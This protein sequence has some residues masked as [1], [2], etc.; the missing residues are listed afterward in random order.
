MFAVMRF[1]KLKTFGN[2]GGVESHCLRS[3]ETL[4]ADP[5]KSMLNRWIVGDGSITSEVKRRI[6]NRKIRKNAVLAIEFLLSASPEYFRPD[7]PENGGEFRKDRVESFEKAVLDWLT[8][9]FGN[10]NIVSVVTH[11]DEQT[12]HLHAIL[13]PID[14][15]T[16]RLN[17]SGWLDGKKALAELQTSFANSVA[18]LG[19]KRG[20]ERSTAT[21]VRIS[22]YYVHVNSPITPE[23]PKI[24]VEPPPAMMLGTSRIEWAQIESDRLVSIQT[25]TLQPLADAAAE[26]KREKQRRKKAELETSRLSRL[27]ELERIRDIP[28]P[29]VFAM[30]GY[31]IDPDDKHQYQGPL[32]R[33][34]TETK[35]GKAKF[36]NHDR[37]K[38]GGGAIDLVMHLEEMDF[39]GVCA[40]LGGNFN[41]D[42]ISKAAAH[43][44]MQEA[45]DALKQPVPL[46]TPD[47]STWL[48]V[49]EYLIY[50][51]KIAV[52]TV[53][54]LY[55]KGQLF[56]DFRGNAC[57]RYGQEGVEL[58]GTTD[59]LW[60]GFRG[61]KTGF[62][63]IWR[64]D[65]TKSVAVCESAIEAMSYAELNPDAS[66]I[67]LSG[68]GGKK[69][70]EALRTLKSKKKN[71]KIYA[72]F[73]A[74]IAG[75]EA[76]QR[77]IVA[78]PGVE[79]HRPLIDGDDWNNVLQKV[80]ETQASKTL[81]SPQEQNGIRG[82]NPDYLIINDQK[83]QLNN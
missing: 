46:P 70:V 79:R 33:I 2:I 80:K 48:K 1:E 65:I 24:L 32:G 60:R 30:C 9:K 59:H 57:F 6:G 39:S 67:S 83:I 23:L 40:F 22:E 43:K 12:P 63:S 8:N 21:H 25:S 75:D 3:R 50:V 68:L 14:P 47:E 78:L 38:G 31:E 36:Y 61:K 17:A 29:A 27:L 26:Q 76:A 20:M 35:N 41:A 56:S 10:E 45:K 54:K 49:R 51:R 53:D 72:A 55:S 74:D 42:A 44:A 19:L 16:D 5:A 7:H 18:H 71:M 77:L 52:T 82:A 62:F 15:T 13:V 11:L 73:N 28:L 34:S 58:R 66:V 37:Q 69:L 64:G 4:N 81:F